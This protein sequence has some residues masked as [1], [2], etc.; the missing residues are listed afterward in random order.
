MDLITLIIVI[1][2]ILLL[3]WVVN[4]SGYMPL[5]PPLVW[6]FNAIVLV[7]ILLILLHLTGVMNVHSVRVGAPA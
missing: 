5:P 3:L 2:I 6:I 4:V 1:G 7:V